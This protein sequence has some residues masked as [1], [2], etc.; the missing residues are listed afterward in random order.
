MTFTLGFLLRAADAS[1]ANKRTTPKR[2][3]Q[4]YN[5]MQ[6]LDGFKH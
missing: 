5:Q 1:A 3:L 6:S 2:I 4:P